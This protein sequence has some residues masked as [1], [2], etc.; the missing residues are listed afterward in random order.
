LL[1]E[2]CGLKGELTMAV[3]VTYYVRGGGVVINGSTTVPTQTQAQQVMKQSAVCVFGIVDDVQALFTHNWGL[4]ISAG[5]FYE[6]E[7][8]VEPI[9]V[10]STSW[11]LLTFWRASSNVLSINRR[12]GDL[13]TTVLITLRRPHSTGQ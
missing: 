7:I 10:L 6:P 9:S 4:D 12:A 5:P 11:P 13:A 2:A 1:V 8:L 3:S